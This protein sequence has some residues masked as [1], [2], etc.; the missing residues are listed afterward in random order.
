M[1][2]NIVFVTN[3]VYALSTNAPVPVTIC[4]DFGAQMYFF[5]QGAALGAAVGGTMGIIWCILRAFRA[6]RFPTD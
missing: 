1:E 4:Y 6:P 3:F 5:W 2:T